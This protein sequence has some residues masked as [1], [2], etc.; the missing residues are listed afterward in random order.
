MQLNEWLIDLL[1]VQ[2][3]VLRIWSLTV[4]YSFDQITVVWYIVLLRHVQLVCI[5]IPTIFFFFS[6]YVFI[7]FKQL[8]GF[9]FRS[10]MGLGLILCILVILISILWSRLRT[11]WN[12]LL[13]ID[14]AII[15]LSLTDHRGHHTLGEIMRLR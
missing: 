1:I 4:C 11:I 2:R 6:N 15:A 9:I 5:S 13:N 7:I 3:L 14:H 8:T 10:G 12:H